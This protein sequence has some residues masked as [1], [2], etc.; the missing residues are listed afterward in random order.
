MYNIRWEAWETL[1]SHCND[2]ILNIVRNGVFRAVDLS[3]P[4]T[5][6]A[7]RSRILHLFHK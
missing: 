1:S 5:D 3:I 2:N 4:L 6:L 7:S